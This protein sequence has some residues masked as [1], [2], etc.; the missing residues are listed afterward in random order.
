MKFEE[1]RKSK[2]VIRAE[3][4]RQDILEQFKGVP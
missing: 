1:V 4:K 3:Q 2:Q